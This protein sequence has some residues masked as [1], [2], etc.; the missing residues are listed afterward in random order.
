MIRAEGALELLDRPVSAT[1]RAASLADIDR[2]NAWFGGYALTLREIRRVAARAPARRLVV[3]HVGGGH[4]AVAPRLRRWARRTGRAIPVRGGGR[5][6]QT[7]PLARPV[8]C[9]HPESAL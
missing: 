5:A 1:E 7:L 4:A 6:R 9:A 3:L 2:L 8:C